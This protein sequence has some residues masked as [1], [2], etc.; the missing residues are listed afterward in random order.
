MYVLDRHGQPVPRGATGELFIGGPGVGRGY[1]GRDDLNPHSFVPDPFSG[2]PGARLYRSGDLVRQRHDGSL[3]FVARGDRQ[4]K[5]RGNRVEPGE[6]ESVLAEHPNVEQ[7]AVVPRDDGAGGHRL[8]AYVVPR[9]GAL[10]IEDREDAADDTAP[11]QP[12]CAQAPAPGLRSFA[13]RQ[14]PEYMVPAAFVSLDALPRGPTGKLDGR[15]LPEPEFKSAES[16]FVA[17]R[18]LV[19]IRLARIW[20]E[21]LKVS[22]VGASDDFFA[23]GG[24][25][26]LGAALFVRVE[27]EF[28]RRL[29]MSVLFQSPSL[30]QMASVIRQQQPVSPW[31]V[32]VQRGDSSRTPFFFV[33]E[34]IGYKPLSEELGAEWPVYVVLYQNLYKHQTERSMRD[35]AAELAVK[36]REVQPRGPYMLGGICM[37]GWVSF[38]IASEL[39]RQGEEVT[40]LAIFDSFAPAYLKQRASPMVRLRRFADHFKFHANNL[41]HS[42]HRQRW[43]H[44][45][46][47]LRTLRWHLSTK[48]WWWSHS[49]YVRTG[50][51]LPRMLRQPAFLTAKAAL[52]A[53]PPDAYPGR[54]ALFRPIQR[55][56]GRFDD[57]YLGWLRISPNVELYEVPGDHKHMLL[58]PAVGMI[59]AQLK[60]CLQGTPAEV[61]DEARAIA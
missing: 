58:P 48:L 33:E 36:V 46:D 2:R 3:E 61:R 16:A 40:L 41:V 5:I 38:A 31:V 27:K 1:L 49:L 4:I 20:E 55:P 11:C 57:A 8:V 45:K 37:A 14:L 10:E 7:V 54:I 42:D 25:S 30:E 21:T 22:R 26:V 24:H 56:R 60:A 6:V 29:P 50:R 52:T 9:Q 12:G 35:I 19:E 23:L 53:G 18:D 34:R 13:R 39:V 51:P 28:G 44:L 43:W 59:A 15:A 17:P 32:E 47:R